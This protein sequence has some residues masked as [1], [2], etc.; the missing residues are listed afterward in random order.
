ME[1]ELRE[2]HSQV[3]RGPSGLNIP[4]GTGPIFVVHVGEF[5]HI[6]IWLDLVLT[7]H[8]TMRREVIRN[9]ELHL[10]KRHWFFW[11]RTITSTAVLVEQGAQAIHN[12]TVWKPVVLEPMS[13][14]T[15]ISVQA[16]GAIDYPVKKL[17]HKMRLVLEFSMVGPRRHMDRVLQDIRHDPKQVL[18]TP[19]LESK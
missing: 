3:A 10:K 8:R 15:I 7:N 9:C 16:K 12:G 4:N 5:P 19:N 18:D 2:P 14:P 1:L 11:E 6:Y 13:V 17:P